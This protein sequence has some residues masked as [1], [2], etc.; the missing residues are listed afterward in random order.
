MRMLSSDGLSGISIAL[1]RD[2]ALAYTKVA[3]LQRDLE[4]V[5]DRA[6]SLRASNWSSK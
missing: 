3:R 4:D 1:L 6:P 5:R 2:R